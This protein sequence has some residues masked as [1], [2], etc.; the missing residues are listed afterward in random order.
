MKYAKIC[1]EMKD[2]PPSST[3]SPLV[4]L[5]RLTILKSDKSSKQKS[6]LRTTE[7]MRILI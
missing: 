4:V 1:G 2:N 7:S 5:F 3:K 6:I